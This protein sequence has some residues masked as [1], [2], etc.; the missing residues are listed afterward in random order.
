MLMVTRDKQEKT[1]ETGDLHYFSRLYPVATYSTL[2]FVTGQSTEPLPQQLVGTSCSSA[3]KASI[4]S[5][6]NV[7]TRGS[8]NE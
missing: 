1:K 8:F 6:N 5:N 3:A 4:L 7:F 2:T